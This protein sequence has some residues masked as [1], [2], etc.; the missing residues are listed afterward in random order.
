MTSITAAAT[1]QH[2]AR[3]TITVDG[4]EDAPLQV[5]RDALT[6]PLELVLGTVA[7]PVESTVVDDAAV[8]LNRPVFYR[9]VASDGT[10]WV[11]PDPVTVESRLSLLS[12][13]IGGNAVEVTIKEWTELGYDQRATV[14]DVEGAAQQVRLHDVE[15]SPQSPEIILRTETGDQLQ[16]LRALFGAG[17]PLLLRG[18]CSGIEDAWL[19][20]TRRA[21]QRLT[22]KASDWR[23]HHVLSDVVHT[24]SPDPSLRAQGDTL[25]DLAAYV[26]AQ[27]GA[28]GTLGDIAA[29]WADGTLGDIAATD[30]GAS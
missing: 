27:L 22:T 23:R 17:E 1:S 9:L 8:L 12:D 18:A 13:P 6:G 29:I 15:S 26:D 24:T 14:L 7:L 16:V 28:A 4:T 20:I 2:T 30:L 11:T 19:G 25:G 3:I 10:S 21:E 5:Y